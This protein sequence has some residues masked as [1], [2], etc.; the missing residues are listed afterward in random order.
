MSTLTEMMIVYALVAAAFFY[1][2][3]GWIMKFVF[4]RESQSEDGCGSC[5]SGACSSCKAHA[6]NDQ[7]I[8]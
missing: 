8:V 2:A 4:K 5:E 3:R 1:V 6:F 7:K